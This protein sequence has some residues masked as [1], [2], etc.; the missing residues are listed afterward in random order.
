MNPVI[1]ARARR[2]RAVLEEAVGGG[3]APDLAERIRDRLANEPVR[4][5]SSPLLVAAAVLA[6]VGIVVWTARVQREQPHG[7]AD[8]RPVAAPLESTVQDPEGLVVHVRRRPDTA[9][10]PATFAWQIG[11]RSL[12]SAT[13]LKR[14]LHRWIADPAQ[15]AA[16]GHPLPLVVAADPDVPW[17]QVLATTDHALAAGCLQIGFAGLGANRFVCKGTTEAAGVQ[18]PTATF[19]QPDEEPHAQRPTFDVRADGSVLQAGT[20]LVPGTNERA[21]LRVRLQALRGQL[22]PFGEMAAAPERRVLRVPLRLRAD[23]D[24][25]WRAVQRVLQE[26]LEPQIGFYV[27][28]IAVAADVPPQGG[29]AEPTNTGR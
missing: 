20:V 25:P 16:N 4:R 24:A 13:E 17:Q 26:A 14:H 11:E 8:P 3:A 27:L 12:E 28:E 19:Q 1:E 21:A 7:A 9:G 23:R 29:L 22:L 2:L 18:L 6:G 10:R 15:R 5:R